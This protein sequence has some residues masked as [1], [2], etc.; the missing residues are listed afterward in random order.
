MDKQD[1]RDKGDKNNKRDSKNK[2]KGD[3]GDYVGQVRQGRQGGQR[4]K[5]I[6]G[7]QGR[8]GDSGQ[9]GR[10]GGGTR[11]WGRRGE[12]GP[13]GQ[14]WR[15]RQDKKGDKFFCRQGKQGGQ[16]DKGGEVT[17][18]GE[19]GEKGGQQ[20]L[21][22]RTDTGT[23]A[24]EYGEP[25]HTDGNW[26]CKVGAPSFV[27]AVRSSFATSCIVLIAR[28]LPWQG[29]ERRNTIALIAGAEVPRQKCICISVHMLVNRILVEPCPCCGIGSGA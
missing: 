2:R 16:A 21:A 17:G 12:G 14:G 13:E 11:G 3:N 25:V 27:R 28:G 7:G 15:T 1:K 23:V 6:Q 8:Q 20:R 29:T 18:E 5:G 4:A 22:A 10:R 9:W 24:K 19:K 26:K